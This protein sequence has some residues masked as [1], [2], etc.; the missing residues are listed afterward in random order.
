MKARTLVSAASLML[1]VAACKKEALPEAQGALVDSATTDRCGCMA[2]VEMGAQNASD[3]SV[4]LL[5]NAMPEAVAYQLEVASQ[6]DA[7][8]DFAPFYHKTITEGTRTTVN[9]LE[10]N[11]RYFY[12]ITTICGSDVSSPSDIRSFVTADF[13]HGDPAPRKRTIKLANLKTTF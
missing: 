8:D 4:D 9:Q 1:L 3:V 7:P 6:F 10:P 12:R 5:W 2:P 13:H 11:T